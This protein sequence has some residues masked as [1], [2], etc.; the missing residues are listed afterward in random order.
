[1]RF[2]N[3]SVVLCHFSL[4]VHD[5]WLFINST[6]IFF[7][8]LLFS[9]THLW[10]S[11]IHSFSHC[12]SEPKP[13]AY[14]LFLPPSQSSVDHKEFKRCGPFD[15]YINSK[16]CTQRCRKQHFLFKCFAFQ[17][18]CWLAVLDFGLF[19]LL[20]G[21]LCCKVMGEAIINFTHYLV[22]LI[23]PM[24]FHSCLPAILNFI[25]TFNISDTASQH[26]IYQRFFLK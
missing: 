15:P 24:A 8:S 22:D 10:S 21:L 5:I 20:V 16:V 6:L 9:L 12:L 11:F 1:M 25:E 14:L 3:I 7:F 18:L 23:S 19:L 13:S 26:A 4:P 2:R 17:L